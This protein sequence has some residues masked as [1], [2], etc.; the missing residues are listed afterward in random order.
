MSKRTAVVILNWNNRTFLEQFLP[1]VIKHSSS[2]ADIIIAD[3]GSTDD[4]LSFVEKNFPA[5]RIIRNEKNEGFTGG[6]NISLSQIDS[7]FFVLLNSDVKVTENWLA[8]LLKVMDTNPLAGA[9]QPKILSFHFPD[10]FEYA[11]AGGGFIDRYGYPFCRGRI[12]L[13]L[14]KDSHQYDDTRQV[15]WASGACMFVR[16]SVFKKLGGFDPEFFA[17]MEEIDLCWRMQLSGNAV[18][19]CGGSTVFHVGGGSLPKENPRKTYLNFRNNL[20]MIYKNSEP[21]GVNSVL[22]T[23]WFLD[24]LASLKFLFSGGVADFKAVWQARRDFNKL[25]T[26]YPQGFSTINP[27]KVLPGLSIYPKSI[28][29]DYYLCGRKKYTLLNWNTEAKK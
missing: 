11:G 1:D 16:S 18:Y 19:Y 24:L 20:L 10:T 15:F 8:P 13:S 5:I 6:Y 27:S 3:N 26:R 22:R 28:L 25:K 23:R 21:A 7:E 9:V 29:W 12:F 14:E 2:L 17:H 4:S